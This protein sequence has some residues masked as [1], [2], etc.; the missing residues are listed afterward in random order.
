M[1]GGSSDVLIVRVKVL[2]TGGALW[3]LTKIVMLTIPLWPVAGVIVTVRSDPDPSKVIPPVGTMVVL[4]EV[5]DTMSSAAGVSA[6]PIVKGIGSV[7]VFSAVVWFSIGVM[8]G[9]SLM[10]LTVRTKDM[11]V[12]FV[13]SFTVIVI[14]VVPL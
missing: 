3:S 10:G 12:S 2:D 11:D 7:G 8:V 4:L 9:E 14:V 5:A 1:V 13:P 6:S